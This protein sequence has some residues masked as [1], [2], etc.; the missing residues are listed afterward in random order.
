MGRF[1]PQLSLNAL[2]TGLSVHIDTY[3][4]TRLTTHASLTILQFNDALSVQ[5]VCVHNVLPSTESD[6]ATVAAYREEL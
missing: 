2:Y 3:D 5:G 4:N 1:V 6:K